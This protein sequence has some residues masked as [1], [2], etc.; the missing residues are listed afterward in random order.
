MLINKPSPIALRKP[1]GALLLD[2]LRSALSS[3][4]SNDDIST[5]LVELIGFDDIE[6]VM[7]ILSN[8][9]A[10]VKEVSSDV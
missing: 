10:V 4:R 9:P 7:E 6:L 1:N 2:S 3:P 8:R 5:E